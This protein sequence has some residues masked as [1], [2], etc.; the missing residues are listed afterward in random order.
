[1]AYYS[2]HHAGTMAI[3]STLRPTS[4]HLTHYYI[5]SLRRSLS[6]TATFS[7]DPKRRPLHDQAQYHPPNPKPI[8]ALFNSLSKRTA[9]QDDP[10]NN[11]THFLSVPLVNHT[12]RSQLEESFS[13]FR[14][15]AALSNLIPQTAIRPVDSLHIKLG[16]LTLN[17]TTLPSA[18][19]LLQSIDTSD[20]S[21]GFEISLK[22]LEPMF[23]SH[24]SRI[25]YAKS[26]SML[27]TIPH[28]FTQEVIRRFRDAGFSVAIPRTPRKPHSRVFARVVHRIIPRGQGPSREDMKPFL[29]RYKHFVWAENFLVDRISICELPRKDVFDQNGNLLHHVPKEVASLKLPEPKRAPVQAQQIHSDVPEQ[30][31]EEERSKARV[32]E[33]EQQ[34]RDAIQR[35]VKIGSPINHRTARSQDNHKEN[36]FQNYIPNFHTSASASE[37]RRQTD[38]HASVHDR[39]SHSTAA[40]QRQQTPSDPSQAAVSWLLQGWG[41]AN[42]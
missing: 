27:N 37:R 35:D 26:K 4:P 14:K 30:D 42:R 21:E 17:D 9:R 3:R 13:I 5:V 16:F 8:S 10:V 34:T 39:N 40:V 22:S 11:Y 1:M 41:K 6:S 38:A 20:L 2:T 25:L 32:R 28:N 29:A 18:T 24:S 12:S 33:R 36:T 15:D 7:S 19:E 23:S 31:S